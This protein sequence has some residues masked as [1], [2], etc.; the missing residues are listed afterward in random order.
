VR[1]VSGD[2]FEL[3]LDLWEGGSRVPKPET[4]VYLV[5]DAGSHRLAGLTAES[6]KIQ[7]SGLVNNNQW[8]TVAFSSPFLQAPAV[9]TAVSTTADADPVTSRVRLITKDGFEISMQEV[10]AQGDNHAIET[11]SWIAIEKGSGLTEDGRSVNVVDVLVG[12]KATAIS[13]TDRAEGRSPLV[14]GAIAS[15]F[16]EDPCVL[17]Y[18][19]GKN[20][21]QLRLEEDKTADRE[22]NHVTEDGFLFVAE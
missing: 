13:I 16:E 12:S 17:R 21:V 19:K 14:L 20:R 2:R 10:E 22:K 7:T 11:L 15:A 9:F 1:N 5:A 18:K 8:Q 3:K 4:V 6:G